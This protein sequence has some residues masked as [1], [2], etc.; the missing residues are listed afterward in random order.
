MVESCHPYLKETE[1][2]VIWDTNIFKRMKKR[3]R[4]LMIFSQ[5]GWIFRKL[6]KSVKN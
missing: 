4:S 2:L 6:K 5:A 3:R 1:A